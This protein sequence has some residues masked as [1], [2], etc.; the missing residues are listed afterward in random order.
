MD[1]NRRNNI[2]IF[3]EKANEVRKGFRT[4]TAII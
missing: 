3:T 1:I 2:R 4:M